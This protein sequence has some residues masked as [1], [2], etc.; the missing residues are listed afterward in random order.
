MSAGLPQTAPAIDPAELAE[1]SAWAAELRGQ[2]QAVTDMVGCNELGLA[3]VLQRAVVD[4][5]V[6]ELK[7]LKVLESLPGARKV[8]TRRQLDDLDIGFHVRMGELSEH[9]REELVRI[10]GG[11]SV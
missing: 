8:T 7:V 10:F 6:G 4:A 2:W 5:T 9:Q 11:A 1:V 3:E